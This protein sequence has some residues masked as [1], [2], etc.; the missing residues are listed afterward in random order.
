MSNLNNK[1][2]S[3]VIPFKNANKERERNLFYT[4]KYYKKHLPLSKI[5]VVEQDTDTNFHSLSDKPDIHFK[6]KTDN[7]F[8]RKGELFNKG[9]NLSQTEYNSDYIIFADSDCI[10]ERSILENIEQYYTYFDNNFV[11]PYTNKVY[12][13]SKEETIKF[14]NNNEDNVNHNNSKSVEGI[15][16]A[17]GGDIIL[18]A[19]NY[20][21]V[22]GFDERF[23]GWGAEDDAFYNKCISLGI[24]VHRLKAD[25]VHLHHPDFFQNYD[26]YG[27][28]LKTYNEIFTNKDIKE[29]IDSLGYGH[30][31]KPCKK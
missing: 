22:G 4:I 11:L 12:Y 9:Y 27:N 5:I 24:S 29:Y 30:L 28:N 6:I 7:D 17:S 16:M 31:V 23:K 13:L 18:S 2:I 15:R 20:Y 1:I 8:F 26:N 3:V 25:L 19:E 10:I 14:I 21:K